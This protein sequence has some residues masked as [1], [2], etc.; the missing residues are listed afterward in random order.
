LTP[1]YLDA[2]HPAIIMFELGNLY[3]SEGFQRIWRGDAPEKQDP[4]H[5][6]EVLSHYAVSRNYEL[7]ARWGESSCL[8]DVWYVRRDLPETDAMV[9]LIRHNPYFFPDSQMIAH[10]YRNDTPPVACTDPGFAIPPSS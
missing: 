10:D 6:M 5:F 9:A 1:E 7:A 2:N 3:G 8:V 4:A